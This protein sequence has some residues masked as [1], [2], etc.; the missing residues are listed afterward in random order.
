VPGAPAPNEAALTQAAELLDGAHRPLILAGRGAVLARAGEALEELAATTGAILATSAPAKGLFHDPYA[1]GISGGFASPHAQELIPP[2]DVVLVAGASVNHWTTR[3]GKL[4]DRQA[5]VIQVDLEPRAIARN[6]PADLALIADVGEAARALVGRVGQKTAW[7]TLELAEEIGAR[8]WPSDPYD[9][10]STDEFIDPRTLSIALNGLLPRDRAVVVDSGHFMGYP[11]MFLD[12]PDAESWVFMNGYQ[13]VGLGIGAGIGA[14]VA[15]PGRP[16]VAAV[17]DGGAFMAL[18]EL[19]TAARLK[20]E[21]LV[22]IYDDAAYGAEVHHFEPMG[23][24]VTRVRFPDRDLAAIAQAAGCKAATIRSTDE[25]SI[26]EEWVANPHGPLVLDAKVNP[27]I[28]AEW[29]A[30]AFRGG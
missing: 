22:V 2:A 19:E 14:S 4:I 1:V 21:L 15:R 9:D 7:R 5:T 30:E 16:T 25:L 11:S 28:C 12:V 23:Y 6:W 10:A 20:L 29:L 17:G 18:Q 26:V 13:A 3:L 24:D 27:T 8:R